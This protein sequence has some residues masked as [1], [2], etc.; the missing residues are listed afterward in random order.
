MVESDV[1]AVVLP[2]IREDFT[3]VQFKLLGLLRMLCD[4]QGKL[5]SAKK[6]KICGTICILERPFTQHL[7][8]RFGERP[9]DKLHTGEIQTFPVSWSSLVPVQ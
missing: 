5:P 8:A 4:G 6:T 1:L 3:A 9:C 7:S 2:Y